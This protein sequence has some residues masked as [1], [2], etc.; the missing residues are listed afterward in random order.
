MDK[1][2]IEHI[3]NTLSSIIHWGFGILFL[4]TCPSEISVHHYITGLLFLLA[5]I[6]TIPLTTEQLEKKLKVQIPGTLRFFVVFVIVMVAPSVTPHTPIAV[7]NSTIASPPSSV[8]GSETLVV[9]AA[10]KQVVTPTS[11]ANSTPV[12][13]QTPKPTSVAEPTPTS[14]PIEKTTSTLNTKGKLDIFTNPAGATIT[15]DGISKGVSPIERLSVPTETHSVTVYLSGYDPQKEN[16]DV[17][18]SETKKLF[19]TLIPETKQSSAPTSTQEETPTGVQNMPPE[20][21]SALV[22]LHV[23]RPPAVTLNE[24]PE[25]FHISTGLR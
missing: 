5:A 3:K 18:N 24:T 25:E 10:P 19:Y 4:L 22:K 2:E 9:A 17:T 15:I 7:N 12:A 13:T 14:N 6:V 11:V 21:N 20:Y 23:H 8:N 16:I 1:I